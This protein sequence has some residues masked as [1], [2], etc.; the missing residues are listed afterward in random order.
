M[1]PFRAH[2]GRLCFQYNIF[3]RKMEEKVLSLDDYTDLCNFAF[4]PG[5]HKGSRRGAFPMVPE[6]FV[7]RSGSVRVT[8]RES[9]T[10]V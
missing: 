2:V 9:V 8:F 6:A 5:G 7:T 10:D 3:R 1:C 4:C